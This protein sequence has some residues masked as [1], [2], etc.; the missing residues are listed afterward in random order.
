MRPLRKGQ[1]LTRTTLLA[2]KGVFLTYFSS[3]SEN[4]TND[5]GSEL[6][7]Y[8]TVDRCSAGCER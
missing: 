8:P 2:V 6:G 5:G 7:Q 3:R 4:K 1:I